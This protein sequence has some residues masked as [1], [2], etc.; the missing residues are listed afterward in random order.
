[1]TRDRELERRLGEIEAPDETAAE[2]RAWELVRAAH[3]ERIPV[4]RRRG[5]RGPAAAAAAAAALALGIGLSPAGAGVADLVTGV[6]GI[7]SG[8][9]EPSLDRLPAAGEVLVEADG[10]WIVRGDGSKRRLGSY[11]QAT[12]SPHGRY[13]AATDGR[14][15]AVVDPVGEVRWTII[16]PRAVRDPRW[17]GTDVDTRIAYRSGGDL[18]VVAGDGTGER[19]IARDVARVA[20][21]WRPAADSKL[22]AQGPVHVVTY[23]TRNG[24]VRAVDADSGRRIPP[25]AADR[26]A[27]PAP[28]SARNRLSGRAVSPVTG[29]RAVIRE[30]GTSATL[31]VRE[32][33]RRDVRVGLPAGPLTGP[34][35]SPD[36]RWLA[37]G[38]PAGD[39]WLFIRTD[40]RRRIVAFGDISRQFDP[41]GGD[42]G[43]FPR[44]SGWALPER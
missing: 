20:P 42:G 25:T 36:G 22:G 7:G 24:R 15:L 4:R 40:R 34:T 9:P 8:D 11:G 21:A 29:A 30:R 37:V 44:I 14:Q 10:V 38:W 32:P 3:A 27:V 39:Q 26:A 41:G 31:I 13:V 33:E 17:S 18:W 1:M 16:A 23:R 19:R 5:L 2:Q 43:R 6:V 12:W 35:W 28:P